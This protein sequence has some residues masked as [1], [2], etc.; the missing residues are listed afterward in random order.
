MSYSLESILGWLHQS[1]K[2]RQYA[3]LEWTTNEILQLHRVANEGPSEHDGTWS[4]C[5]SW[6]P[7]TDPG[8]ILSSLNI[9]D[10]KHPRIPSKD[11][12]IVT[13]SMVS[14][15]DD[16]DHSGAVGPGES[17]LEPNC[18]PAQQP[19]TPQ[20]A[21]NTDST[22]PQ[23]CAPEMTAVAVVPNSEGQ[24]AQSSI[25]SQA[26]EPSLPLEET[27]CQIVPGNTSQARPEQMSGF[28]HGEIL[29]PHSFPPA[30]T[31]T[32]RGSM[33]NGGSAMDNL[34]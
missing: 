17:S 14:T 15:E 18:N 9:S 30:I 34:I 8:V 10:L 25:S 4:H 28:N 12:D 13:S 11:Q 29:S 23:T 31:E 19:E 33:R 5:T 3:Y 22:S 27:P 20:T 16:T 7:T 2:Y 24:V 6:V 32:E 26:V 21:V 1:R